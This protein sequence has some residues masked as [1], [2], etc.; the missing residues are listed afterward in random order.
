MVTSIAEQAGRVATIVLADQPGQGDHGGQGE[1][2]GKSSPVGL[3]LLLLFLI[4]VGLLVRSMN[5]HL[6][7]VPGSFDGDGRSTDPG[8]D[9]QPDSGSE[10]ESATGSTCADSDPGDDEPDPRTAAGST[11]GSR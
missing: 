8:S 1:D 2:F 9:D 10:G 6:G 7:R 11:R 3:L 4:A 5:R